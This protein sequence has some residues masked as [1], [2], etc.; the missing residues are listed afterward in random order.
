MET[1]VCTK[2]GKRKPITEYSVI[3]RNNKPYILPSCKQCQNQHRTDYRKRTHYTRDWQ[4]RNTLKCRS[5]RLKF[6]F[7]LTLEDYQDLLIG[8]HGK[9]AICG[10][11]D[12]SPLPNFC[13]DHDHLTGKIR[14]LLCFKCNLMLGLIR[15]NIEI[16]DS[17][18]EYLNRDTENNLVYVSE[19]I[20][21]KRYY[22]TM[23]EE[24]NGKCL[25]CGL[26]SQKLYIDHDHLTG[27]IRG[28]LC[29]NCNTALGKLQDDPALCCAAAN[30]L[31]ANK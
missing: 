29:N 24:Q 1:K 12:T 28:L 26:E 16:L 7:G 18:V 13:V 25:I 21:R 10:T 23:F 2:C 3:Q 4:Q 17:A 5:F 19:Y 30:Y 20:N 6:K 31:E 15:D 14:G 27:K 11:T 22:A 9:C 8:Q